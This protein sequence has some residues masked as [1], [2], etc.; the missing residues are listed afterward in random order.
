MKTSNTENNKDLRDRLKHSELIQ[1]SLYKIAKAAHTAKNLHDLYSSIHKIISKL[2][3]AENF[4]IAIFD[5]ENNYLNF[6]YYVDQKDK[7]LDNHKVKLEK[8]SLTGHCLELGVPLLYRKK[9]IMDLEKLGEVNPIGTLS[10]V[11]IGSPL[12]IDDKTMGVIVVQSYNKKQMLT[13][14][15]R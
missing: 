3:Y 8:K 1:S 5:K 7:E 2:M 12:K 4:Y 6:P 13:V 14:E 11:W 9:D 15:D 10:E